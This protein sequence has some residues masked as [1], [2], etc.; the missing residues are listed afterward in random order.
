[1]RLLL[2]RHGQTPSNVEGILDAGYPGPGLTA[3]GRR[4]A[5]AIPGALAREDIAGMHV[6]RLLRTHETAAPLAAALDLSPRLTAGLEEIS[7]GDLQM[8]RDRSA[9]TAY[10]E[11]H[12]RWSTGEFDDGVPGGETGR[13]FW[14]RY[15]GALRH[16]AGLY[17]EDATVVVVSH[18]AAIRVFAA[19]VGGIGAATLEERPLFN[20]GMVTLVGHPDRG[21]VLE[22]WS[23]DPV[24]GAHLLGDTSHDVTADQEADAAV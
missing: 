11:M 24:G 2:L 16:I 13:V 8:R 5:E 18:G 3:L 1:M 22:D 4:Q 23:S 7:A 21:W 12:S 10:Q 6:S 17:A 15:T 14:D 19:V 20:T 9:I